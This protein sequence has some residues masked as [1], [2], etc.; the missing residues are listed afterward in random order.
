MSE[1]MI[2]PVLLVITGSTLHNTNLKTVSDIDFKGF[3]LPPIQGLLGL[4]PFSQ[5]KYNNELTGTAKIEG[6][7]ESLRR[8]LGFIYD[9]DLAGSETCFADSRFHVYSISLAQEICEFARKNLLSKSL[10]KAYT[11][12]FKSQ[13]REIKRQTR[14]GDRQWMIVQYGYDTKFAGHAYRLGKQA[15]DIMRDGTFSPTLSEEEGNKVRSIR[16]GAYTFDQMVEL[17]D[18]LDKEMYESYQNST[19]REQADRQ[20]LNNFVIDIQQRYIRGEF[21]RILSWFTK[22]DVLKLVEAKGKALANAQSIRAS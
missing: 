3:C 2:A 11:G 13:V 8:Q 18:K 10:F 7:V 12:Y 15:I 4:D 19:I 16:T 5:E 22:Q 9:G 6:V 20:L 21:D 17:L 1:N 14:T